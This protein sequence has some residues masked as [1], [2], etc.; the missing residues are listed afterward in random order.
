M[1][2]RLRVGGNDGPVMVEIK[3]PD[4]AGDQQENHED[5]ELFL[6]FHAAVLK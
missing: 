5:G 6:L 3:K 2:S 4:G 1:D